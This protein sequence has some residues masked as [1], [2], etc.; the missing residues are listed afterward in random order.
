MNKINRLECRICGNVCKS[1]SG[2]SKHIKMHNLSN[3][4]YYDTYLK[5][6]RE[7]YCNNPSCYNFVNYMGFHG[8]QKHCSTRCSTLNPETQTQMKSTMVENHGVE[9]ALQSDKIFSKMKQKN[10]ENHGTEFPVRLEESKEK[11]KKTSLEKYGV[12]HPTR[13]KVV[14]KKLI[15]SRKGKSDWNNRIKSKSTCLKKYGVEN[16][17]QVE[18]IKEKKNTKQFKE[19]RRQYMI[20]GGAAHCNQFIQNPS[21][22][23]IELYKLTCEIA[24]YVI[25]N[26]PYLNKSID[27]A[28][29]SLSIAIEY[30]GTYWH[31][32]EEADNK[33]QSLLEEDGWKFI[34]YINRVPFKKELK[35]DILGI[36]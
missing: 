5:K 22:P 29:P 17:S 35:N 11:S 3:K 20:N 6:Y 19:L 26:Y 21:K 13:S 31:Q 30:D 2:L 7:E 9:Y 8:Y 32:D 12:D 23:Q 34:R 14:K 25:M 1:L 27:I 36:I 18:E 28:I 10:L 16:V 24:P 33:R 4:E 15:E